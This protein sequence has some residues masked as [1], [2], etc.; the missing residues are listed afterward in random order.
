MNLLELW[1]GVECTVNRVG[2]QY[3]NQLDF[4]GHRERIEDLDA[5][6]AL[7]IRRLRYP[8]LWELTAPHAAETYDWRWADQRLERLRELGIDPIIGFVHHGSGPR[9]TNLLDANFAEALA[10]YARAFATRFPHIDHYTPVNEPLTTAR[11]SALYALW[12]PHKRDDRSFVRA[13]INQCRAVV[14]AMRAIREINP[15]ARLVQTEDLGR[16]YSTPDLQYQADFENERRWLTWDLLSGRVDKHHALWRYLLRARVPQAELEEFIASPCPPDIFG[17]NHYVTSD[18]FLHSDLSQYDRRHWG[19]N[20]IHRYVDLEAVRV[21]NDVDCGFTPALGELW[22]R[23]RKPIVITEAHLGCT[24]E[25]QLRWLFEAWQAAETARTQGI[26]IRAV[27]CWALYGSYHWNTLLTRTD[28]H[29]EAGAFDV[30]GDKPRPTALARLLRHLAGGQRHMSPV[31][32][33]PGWWRR[34]N[35]LLQPDSAHVA[36][37]D[38]AHDARRSPPVLITGAGTLGRAFARI[39]E[40]RGLPYVLC[41][42]ADLNIC[43]R[44]ALANKLKEIQPWC[45]VN[46]AGYVRV[47]DAE[48]DAQ[49]CYME[50]SFGPRTLA[51]ACLQQ[52]IPFLTFSS[53]LVFD[54][55]SS[56]PYRESHRVAP[57]NVYG[58]SKARAERQI[59]RLYPHAL[60]IRTSAFFGPWDDYNFMTIVL[61]ELALGSTFVAAEDQVVSP[62]YVPDLVNASLDLLIDGE[63]GL[64]HVA[65]RGSIS[66]LEFAREGAARAR[67]NTK[68]LRAGSWRTLGQRAPRPPYSALTSERGLLLPTLED[69]LDRYVAAR[70]A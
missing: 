62:T 40:L 14:L 42:R 6:A 34:P 59:L 25:E 36:A 20:G 41:A 26:D 16:I 63:Y 15:F 66:W 49:R 35:R 17:L 52:D 48:R 56:S 21:A 33:T 19:G 46:T 37:F 45:I 50:N 3:L 31:L 10:R 5:L 60:V 69:A 4:N 22:S 53:D 44:A 70:A 23:Y 55:T 30:R 11:F 1:G 27:T 68:S 58:M 24:R 8:I 64:W 54:G 43:D 28:G 47:D 13:V 38:N 65:N 9:Y 32:D 29:Y 2:E 39:C 51:T 7:G 18:R 12:Y 61:R 57:L 67:V